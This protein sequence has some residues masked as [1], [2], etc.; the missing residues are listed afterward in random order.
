MRLCTKI[1]SF[2]PR[3]SAKANLTQ[4]KDT[5]NNP[6][7][8][9]ELVPGFTI[10]I[11]WYSFELN[12]NGNN[13]LYPDPT[14]AGS[15]K[16]MWESPRQ[17]FWFIENQ[18]FKVFKD[19]INLRFYTFIKLKGTW[20]YDI[21]WRKITTRITNNIKPFSNVSTTSSK[22]NA[23]GKFYKSKKLFL[24]SSTNSVGINTDGKISEKII[25]ENDFL[26]SVN[27]QSETSTQTTNVTIDIGEESG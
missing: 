17:N 13:F 24:N 20:L 4:Y 23:I 27:T 5:D 21:L 9:D 7:T 25:P 11:P 26:F 6:E 22:I 2:S 18:D 12:E 8:P 14:A 3:S 16:R 15:W 10:Y 1:S 19:D